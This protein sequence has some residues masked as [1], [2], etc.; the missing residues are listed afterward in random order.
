MHFRCK[1]KK[2]GEVELR[3][4]VSAVSSQW[5]R[6]RGLFNWL[7]NTVVTMKACEDENQKSFI[8]RVHWSY[9]LLSSTDVNEGDCHCWQ[10]QGM[11][12]AQRLG[13]DF[14]SK[15]LHFTPPFCL[16][17]PTTALEQQGGLQRKLSLKW[18]HYP[19]S[20]L[21]E[22]ESSTSSLQCWVLHGEEE[23]G[24]WLSPERGHALLHR[25]CQ[26]D[27]AFLSTRWSPLWHPQKP[28]KHSALGR[29]ALVL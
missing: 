26:C 12:Q 22:E 6:H 27:S 16:P 29:Q 17:S 1:K 8:P 20:C 4:G 18:D 19:R 5:L 15:H 7:L 14:I 3:I 9:S 21:A 24:A 23:Q 25:C 28:G 11:K 10:I 2:K 13:T